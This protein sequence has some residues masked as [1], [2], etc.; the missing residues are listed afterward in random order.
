MANLAFAPEEDDYDSPLVQNSR[1]TLKTVDL[2][3]VKDVRRIYLDFDAQTNRFGT[4]SPWPG[5]KP[6][7]ETNSNQDDADILDL[8]HF[9]EEQR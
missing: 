7:I 9:G 6:E 5:I 1:S 8:S 2:D 3:P 4:V